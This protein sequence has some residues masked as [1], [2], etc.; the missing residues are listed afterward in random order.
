[1]GPT[2][3]APLAACPVRPRWAVSTKKDRH[4]FL[5]SLHR[6]PGL[7]RGRAPAALHCGFKLFAGGVVAPIFS[8]TR[9]DRFGFDVEVLALAQ[10]LGVAVAE[11]PVRWRNSPGSRVTPGQGA[12]GSLV[13]IPCG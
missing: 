4:D 5:E 6:H 7:R 12:G 9:I 13:S 1:G 8:R 3:R 11:V 10:R 2:R